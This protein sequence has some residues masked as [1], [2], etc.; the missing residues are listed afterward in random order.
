[1]LLYGP[2]CRADEGDRDGSVRLGQVTVVA[3]RSQSLTGLRTVD[4]DSAALHRTVALSM[5]DVIAL[6]PSVMVKTS[7]R[8]TLS[9]VAM[10]G[11]SASHTMVEWNGLPVNSPMLGTTDFSMVPA[12]MVDR[13]ALFYGG[14]SVAVAGGGL[15]GAVVMSN[16]LTDMPEGYS[17]AL[18]Q[19]VGSFF[20]TDT[21]GAIGWSNSRVRLRSQVYYGRSDNDFSYLNRDKMVN[22]YDD[23]HNIIGRYHPRE[24]NTNGAYRDLH[25]MQQAEVDLPGRSVLGAVVWWA[26]INREIPLTTVDYS[27][28]KR[29][30]NRQRDNTLRSVVTWRGVYGGFGIEAKGGYM[31]QWTAY[32]Y[33]LDP[34]S[35]VMSVLTRAHTRATTVMADA[36]VRY[37]SGSERW[38]AEGGAG[39]VWDD[40]QTADYASL[41]QTPGYDK[42][43]LKADVNASIRWQPTAQSGVAAIVRGEFAGQYHPFMATLAA[44]RQVGDIRL[45]V[46]ANRNVRIPTLNDLY[47]MPGGNPSLRPEKSTSFDAGATYRHG[48][49][50]ASVNG[51]YSRIDDWIMWLPTTKGFFSP[52]NVRRVDAY[53]I[54]VTCSAGFGLG[55]DMGLRIDGSYSWSPSVN[56]TRTSDADRS[57]GCQMP[58]IPVHSAAATA[59]LRWHRWSLAWLTSY[60]SKRYTMMAASPGDYTGT[61]PHYLMNDAV[62]ECDWRFKT[63]GLNVKLSLN[64]IFD[65]DYMTVLTHPMPGFNFEAFIG[66]IF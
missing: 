26:D 57:Y 15:G 30:E 18:T 5:A 33:A 47:Y 31:R 19:G 23:D 24:R 12:M 44:D 59:T 43:R 32:D 55:Q 1:M 29:Y 64:N 37:I 4:I 11:A 14:S 8:A 2:V 6:N 60:Y 66:I 3:S 16:T 9:T 51:Y 52:S 61:L 41:T 62:I 20:T 42:S 25:L 17:G 53:G 27:D 35:G 40:V 10:R 54:E 34:G 28:D 13:A 22:L 50:S 48:D 65:V 39:I 7:G 63:F 45:R 46:S 36:K 56:R 49:W 38:S 58:Y 21:W